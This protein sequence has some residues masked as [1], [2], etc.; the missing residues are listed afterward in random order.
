MHMPIDSFPI[1]QCSAI[2]LLCD[3]FYVYEL[4]LLKSKI[5]RTTYYKPRLE[6]RIF[7]NR[8]REYLATPSFELWREFLHSAS[9]FDKFRPKPTQA[10]SK[11]IVCTLVEFFDNLY[12]PVFVIPFDCLIHSWNTRTRR[13]QHERRPSSERN[14]ANPNARHHFSVNTLFGVDVVGVQAIQWFPLLVK[15]VYVL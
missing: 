1:S 9:C 13:C 2:E 10:K 15:F 4:V 7:T 8:I 3:C 12:N 11:I 6:T 5:L 14:Q